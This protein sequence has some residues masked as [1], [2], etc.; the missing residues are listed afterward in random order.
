MKITITDTSWGI[1]R[2]TGERSERVVA[3]ET[4]ELAVGFLPEIGPAKR[5]FEVTKL[6]DGS[7]TILLNIKGDTVTIH[8]GKSYLYRPMS[9]DGGHY[10]LLEVE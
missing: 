10:Y 5:A 4:F 7:V 1:D 9:M 8:R 2:R 3:C 6:T